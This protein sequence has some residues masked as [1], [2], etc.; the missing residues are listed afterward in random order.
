MKLREPN[1][2]LKRTFKVENT[3]QLQIHVETIEVSGYS[4]EGYG[5]K[6]V[7]C[8][9]FALSANASKD[10]IILFTPDFTASRVIRELKFITTSG[11]EFVFVLN[12]SLP[13]H[14]L[15]TCAEALPRP[16]WELALYIIISGIMSALFLLVI[17]TAYL[18]AQGIWEPFRRRL[19]FEA[20]NPP[21]DVGRPFDLRRIVGI[22]S[23]GNLN[24]L[25]C[26]PGHSRGSAEQAA[27]HPDPVQGLTSSVAL[28]ATHTAATAIETQLT[29]KTSGPKTAQAP[30]AGLTPSRLAKRAPCLR[31][32]HSGPGPH[33]RQKIQRGQT[34]PARQPAPRP[35]PA[36]AAF[37][38]AAATAS[39]SAPGATA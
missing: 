28:Q 9:E 26:D 35:W 24:T 10:I 16:N 13:Y 29:W 14:M 11:S 38:T 25:N 23:E 27:Q 33:S 18:E 3:G 36:G 39:A 7:N 19:S 31:I 15:A 5:F 17:G 32:Q 20:S 12:A 30:L 37:A 8:Q 6:V 22:S 21:F 1:F 4:C 2:T 34:E